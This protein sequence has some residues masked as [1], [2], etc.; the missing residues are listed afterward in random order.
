[1]KVGLRIPYQRCDATFIAIQPAKVAQEMGFDV[2]IMS[3]DRPASVLLS[4]WDRL[5][6]RN[7]KLSYEDWIKTGLGC[8]LY[9]E[10]SVMEEITSASAIGVKPYCLVCWNSITEAESKLMSSFTRLICPSR[11]V[12]EL[13]VDKLKLSN[14]VACPWDP[15]VPI[16]QDLRDVAEDNVAVLWP[17]ENGRSSLGFL[18]TFELFLRRCPFVWATVIYYSDLSSAVVKDLRRLALSQ[19]GRVE[20]IK[21]PSWDKQQILYGHHDLTIWPT[22]TENV[23]L[24]GLCSIYMGTPVIAFDHPL[25]GEIVSDGKNGIL[26]PCNLSYNWLEVPCVDPDYSLFGDYLVQVVS[27][28]ELLTRLRRTT[29]N[30]LQRRRKQFQSFWRGMFS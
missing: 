2:E 8:L 4:G 12:K 21:N 19:S 24:V 28:V 27:D 26:V 13:L 9:T 29:A 7:S 22:L 20:L 15:G 3:R 16:T 23:G 5:V 6:L 10:P 17:I 11:C 30:G 25:V 18:D 14:A 1:M